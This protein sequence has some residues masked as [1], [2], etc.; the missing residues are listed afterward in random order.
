MKRVVQRDISERGKA[1]KQAENHFLISWDIYKKKFKEAYKKK[2]TNIIIT[3]STNIDR[4]L[5]KIFDL[6]S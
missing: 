6:S 3:K 2:N 1:K 4:V 5:K